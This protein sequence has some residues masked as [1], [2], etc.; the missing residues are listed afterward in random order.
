MSQTVIGGLAGGF[1]RADNYNA[2]FV[3][4]FD[5][6]SRELNKVRGLTDKISNLFCY[7]TVPRNSFQIKH[8]HTFAWL[9]IRIVKLF[10]NK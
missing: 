2:G 5:L 10:L 8:E 4:I 7:S 6:R 3:A 1:V 9:N